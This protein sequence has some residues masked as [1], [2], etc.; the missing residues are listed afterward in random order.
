MK[1]L[2][3]ICRS[4]SHEKKSCRKRSCAL[5]FPTSRCWS[6]REINSRRLGDRNRVNRRIFYL[7]CT[8]ATVPRAS[9]R[10]TFAIQCHE[11][12]QNTKFVQHSANFQFPIRNKRKHVYKT[13]STKSITRKALKFL[14][15]LYLIIKRKNEICQIFICCF[16]FHPRYTLNLQDTWG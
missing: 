10:M 5:K 11:V 1:K 14:F 13:S 12:Y 15:G 7:S 9:Q 6:V 3:G 8:P 2:A 16:R 4:E